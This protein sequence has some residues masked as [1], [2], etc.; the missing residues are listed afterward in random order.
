MS[1]AGSAKAAASRLALLTNHWGEP[2]SRGPH[3]EKL[4][5]S[6]SSVQRLFGGIHRLSN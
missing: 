2:N 3:D 6:D 5:A 1:G 4:V